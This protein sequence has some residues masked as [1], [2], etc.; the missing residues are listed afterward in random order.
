MPSPPNAAMVRFRP[1]QHSSAV[2]PDYR[3]PPGANPK[4]RKWES[5][6]VN[7]NSG[8]KY[9]FCGA[10]PFKTHDRRREIEIRYLP[11]WSTDKKKKRPRTMPRGDKYV[12]CAIK[13]RVVSDAPMASC[14]MYFFPVQKRLS[15]TQQNQ[16]GALPKRSLQTDGGCTAFAGFQR[17]RLTHERLDAPEF[18]PFIRCERF[19]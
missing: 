10:R 15:R 6:G 11:A 14:S 17:Q 4:D 7:S 12:L 13:K 19:A 3:H 8:V 1:F 9:G 2:K 18:S 16:A 5:L